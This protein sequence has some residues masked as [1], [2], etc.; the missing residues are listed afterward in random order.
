MKFRIFVENLDK[1]AMGADPDGMDFGE[2]FDLPIDKNE[3]GKTICETIGQ[4]PINGYRVSNV[5]CEVADGKLRYDV[6]L[7]TIYEINEDAIMLSE[8]EY[9][10]DDNKRIIVN[11]LL[12][13][14]GEYLKEAINDMD[15][16]HVYEDCYDEEDLGK[17][18]ADEECIR[19]DSELEDYINW[20]DFVGDRF[21]AYD[22]DNG[23]AIVRE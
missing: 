4:S 10:F 2:W 12:E 20:S 14:K 6:D 22:F 1:Q 9:E 3:I 13:S 16:Y 19:Y 5:E 18:I 11:Y 8:N 7:Q 23:Y 21:Y 17:A 15:S